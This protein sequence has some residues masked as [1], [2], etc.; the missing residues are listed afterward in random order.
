MT[1]ELQFRCE[2]GIALI[3]LNRPQARNAITFDM[4]DRLAA[5]CQQLTES[6]SLRALIITGAGDKAFAAGTD[7][8]RFRDFRSGEDALA[9]ERR[10]DQ[11]LDALERVPVPTI[12]AIRGACTGGG[13]AIAISCDLRIASPDLRFGFPIARTLGNCLSGASLARVVS[14]IGMET[15]RQLLYT[16]RL[17]GAEQALSAG[18]LLAVEADPLAQAQS[19]AREMSALAPLTL[20]S[21]KEGLRRLRAAMPKIDDEDLIRNCYESADFREGMTAFFDKR[22]PDWQGR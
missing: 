1:D 21:I 8:S 15:A 7:I 10:I 14:A 20:R 18:F 9:Y 19:L 2:D 6:D 3:T 11:V 13:A 17:M 12:A 4:Y 22:P 5:H 16:A